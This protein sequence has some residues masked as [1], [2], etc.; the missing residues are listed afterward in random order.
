MNQERNFHIFYQLLAGA[1]IHFLKSLKLQRNVNKYELLK[2]TD[3]NEDDKI[4]FAYAKKSLEVLGLSQDEMLSIFKIIAVVLKLG[5]L[6]FI[7]TCQIDG[8]EGCE[9]SNDYEIHEI[10]QL[11]HLDEEVLINC[12]TKTGSN[13]ME[14][15]SELD[16]LNANLM[17]KAL[18]RT[19][20]GRL[21]TFIVNRI[22]E[23]MKVRICNLAPKLIN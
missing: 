3:S 22:N 21:F 19:L 8:T 18:C 4:N 9:I 15:G 2:E 10:A 13:W 12:L 17:T 23:S 6:V 11:L 7:P 16:A 14:N 1:D 20:Y 5:N